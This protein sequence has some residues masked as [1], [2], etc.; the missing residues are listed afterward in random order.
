MAFQYPNEIFV[1]QRKTQTF[2]I[3]SHM[4]KATAKPE[5][6]ARPA[7]PLTI[8]D[9]YSRYTAVLVNTEKSTKSVVA[10]IPVRNV[11]RM[12][13]VT[14]YALKKHLDEMYGKSGGQTAGSAAGPAYTVTMKGGYFNGKTPAAVLVENP[15]QAQNLANQI[16]YLRSKLQKYPDNQKQIDAIEHALSL[17]NQGMLNRNLVNQTNEI[18]IYEATLRPLKSRERHGNCWFIY[19]IK[20]SWIVGEDSPVHVRVS[21]YYAPVEQRNDG[22][23]NVM[24]KNREKGTDTT[25][26]MNLTVDEWL[27]CIDAMNDNKLQFVVNNASACYGEWRQL[28]KEVR[29]ERQQNSQNQQGQP[30]YAQGNPQSYPQGQPMQGNP[31]NYAQGNPQNYPQGQGGYPAGG[32]NPYPANAAGYPAYPQGNY[33]QNR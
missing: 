9:R 6:D 32:Q 7:P 1:A 27:G 8:F 22:T 12:T 16:N 10:N 3:D 24:A 23:Y 2:I 25:N 4:S 18:V 29:E 13:A 28:N 30:N 31:Q 33:P 17:L 11:R 19:D 14:E 15:E 26:E 21:N 20:I 5:N